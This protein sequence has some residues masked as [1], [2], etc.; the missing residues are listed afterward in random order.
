MVSRT[1]SQHQERHCSTD[2]LDVRFDPIFISSFDWNINAEVLAKTFM[3]EL[4]LLFG[5]TEVIAVDA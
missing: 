3:E 4:E 2:E 5:M 1:P